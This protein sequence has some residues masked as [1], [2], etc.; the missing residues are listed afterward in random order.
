MG[1]LD[2]HKRA[3]EQFS[4]TY[5]KFT[6]LKKRLHM[7]KLNMFAGKETNNQLEKNIVLNIK[8]SYMRW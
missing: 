5:E 1:C 4:K 2:Q 7:M 6:V 8:R 3:K